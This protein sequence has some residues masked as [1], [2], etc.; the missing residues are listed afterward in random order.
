MAGRAEDEEIW[1]SLVKALSEFFLVQY[2]FGSLIVGPRWLEKLA[3]ALMVLNLDDTF[4]LEKILGCLS[5]KSFFFCPFPCCFCGASLQHKK[6][7][8][9]KN[10]ESG[11]LAML[12][13]LICCFLMSSQKA[14]ENESPF[15]HWRD[16]GGNFVQN[17]WSCMF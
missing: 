7:K 6:K 11:S 14:R 4:P 1:E 17:T 13:Q 15:L 3:N 16:L 10:P 8:T 12:D 5:L 2:I 9:V